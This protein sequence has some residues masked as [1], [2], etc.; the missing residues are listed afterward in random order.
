MF[1]FF[2]ICLLIFVFLGIPLLFPLS[3]FVSSKIR[4]K[5]MRSF[6]KELGLSFREPVIKF[7][8]FRSS[9]PLKKNIIEGIYNGKK[10]FIYD[11][12][13]FE[14]SSSDGQSPL[15]LTYINIDGKENKIRG[16]IFTSFMPSVSEI[17]RV[18]NSLINS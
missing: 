7:I 14:F 2:T 8:T 5:K 16:P 4:T 13:L 9:Y 11:L 6:A 18:F 17:K 10:I 3:Y 12:I 1:D 15:N